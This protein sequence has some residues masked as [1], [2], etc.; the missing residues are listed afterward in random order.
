M[1]SLR[2]WDSSKS[3][4]KRCK[5]YKVA[6]PLVMPLGR[7]TTRVINS[8][9]NAEEGTGQVRSRPAS[10]GRSRAENPQ[11]WGLLICRQIVTTL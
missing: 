6:S 10:D 9:H 5:T 2:R 8:R 11:K 4:L 7:P 1:A 3:L